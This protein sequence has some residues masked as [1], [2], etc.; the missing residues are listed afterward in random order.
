M[1]IF[2]AIVYGVI[3]GIT[4]F[5]PISSSAHLILLPVFTGWKDPGL[6]FDVALHWGTL[7]AVLLYY[8]RDLLTLA[9]GGVRF[10]A[11]ERKH[12]NILP[13]QILAA[14]I[15]AAV[16]GYL[17]EDLAATA[18]RSPW[19]MV[20][21][22]SLLGVLLWLADRLGRKR[23]PMEAVGWMPALIIGCCQAIALVPGVSR[24]GVTIT[25]ALFLGLDR[26]AAVRFS[27]LL[28]IPITAGA[29][30]LKSPYVMN[31]LGNP[32]IWAGVA[33]SAVSGM[34]AMHVLISY[35]KNRSFTPFVLY[36]IALAV[37][38]AGYLIAA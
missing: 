6:A 23:I 26:S 4:E 35:V 16:I 2:E 12:E 8:W 25:T 3:Q 20:V 37:V 10:L 19:I 33:A 14:T 34:L 15:P 18:F 38:L 31:N 36:R 30:L 9:K 13:W 7:L 24:S 5:L 27:F 28:S 11:G 32:M 17:V 22:L 29:G 21:T 1:T